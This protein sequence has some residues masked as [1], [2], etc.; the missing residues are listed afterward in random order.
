MRQ[1]IFL[2]T[3]KFSAGRK[4]RVTLSNY[5]M[6]LRNLTFPLSQMKSIPIQTKT[7]R[8]RILRAQEATKTKKCILKSFLSPA[9]HTKQHKKIS[10]VP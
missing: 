3:S 7:R 5:P 1:S 8:K 10:T 2:D 6:E 4:F 9:T